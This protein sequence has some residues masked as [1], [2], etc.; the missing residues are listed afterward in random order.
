MIYVILGF[1]MMHGMTKYDI[2][3]GLEKEI[4]PFYAPSYGSINHS[5]KKLLKEGLISFVE[6]VE[7]GRHK[8]VYSITDTG[9]EA[10]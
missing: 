6:A 1:L 8:K 9:K 4:S 5:I 2:K 3:V 7:K 10:S